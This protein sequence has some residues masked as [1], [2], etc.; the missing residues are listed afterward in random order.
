MIVVDE[1]ADEFHGGLKLRVAFAVRDVGAETGRREISNL[2]DVQ[3]ELVRNQHIRT[4]T[5]NITFEHLDVASTVRYMSGVHIF[6]SVHGAGMTNMFFMNPGT[7]VVEIIPYPLCDCKSP[8]YFYGIGGYYHGSSVAQGIKH[9]PYCVPL[10]HVKWQ[11]MPEN[12]EEYTKMGG[13]CSWKFLHAVE[14]VKLEVTR[15]TSLLRQ[16]ERDM[17]ASG[18]IVLT[19]P[20]I[21][22]HPHANGRI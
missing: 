22:M 3:R 11:T 8:D 6:I 13:K 18:S 20:I 1:D 4:S 16:V 7:A 10:E 14:S 21:N 17:I 2:L 15:F 19:K 5:E 12:L 9:Y